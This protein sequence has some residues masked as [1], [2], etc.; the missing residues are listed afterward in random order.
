MSRRD[1][2]FFSSKDGTRLFWRS[3]VPDGAAT[4]LVA[5]VHGYG[6]H[7]GRYLP[8]MD[9][10][11]ARGFATLAFDYRGHGKADGARAD[12]GAWGD[13][14]DDLDAFWRK[15]RD[16][17]GGLPVFLLGHS[18]GALIATHWVA[19]RPDGL[20]GLVLTAPFYALAFKPPALKLLA[21]RL[22]KGVVPGLKLGNELKPEQLSR[23]P[24]W[25][26][27]TSADPLYLHTTTPRWFFET[28]GAQ[29][30]LTGLGRQVVAP[31]LM[32]AGGD[33][34]IAKMSAA[35]GFFE[36]IASTDKTWKEYPGF[37]H[38]V[39]NE[40]GKEQVIDDIARWISAHR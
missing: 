28:A 3:A 5:I 34:P 30:R 14:L 7:S 6:D 35:R 31:L 2:G 19:Q 38:E 9:A 10:L 13:Y 16:R 22:L 8:T 33:D 17:A 15:A 11:V 23:D 21:A 4:A 39:L 1:E 18:N 20:A 36:T 27:Q 26:A 32:L 12:C 37:R 29:Q 25:Q 24:A 40:T